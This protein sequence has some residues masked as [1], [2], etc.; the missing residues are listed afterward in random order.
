MNVLND[1]V[2]RKVKLIESKIMTPPDYAHPT[3]VKMCNP[4]TM[5][6]FVAPENGYLIGTA[7]IQN[8]WLKMKLEGREVTTGAG[9]GVAY[10]AYAHMP[11]YLPVGKGQRFNLEGGDYHTLI[12]YPC[13]KF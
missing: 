10:N 9:E 3:I 2:T 4:T 11:F 13:L 8:N 6:E 12:F 7:R 5:T 1:M